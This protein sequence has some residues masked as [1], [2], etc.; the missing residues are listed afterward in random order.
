MPIP[1]HPGYT[2]LKRSVR[3]VSGRGGVDPMRKYRLSGLILAVLVLAVQ[4]HA[5]AAD[6]L[7][8]VVGMAAYEH[9]APLKNTV[10][11][12]RAIADT[13][14]RIGFN[15]VTLTDAT[16]DELLSTL[17]EFSFRAET[18]D[19]ALIYFAGHGVEVQGENFLIPV[20][21][22]VRSNRDVAARSVSLKDLLGAV[23]RA[24]K[25]RIVILDSCRDN[26]FGDV[27]APA[28]DPAKGAGVGRGGG[29]LA[30]PAPDRGTLVAFAARDGEIALDGDGDN[31]PFALALADTLARPGLEISLMFRQVRDA[32][33]AATGNRQEPHT[34]GSLPGA[35][36]YLA[37]APELRG[38]IDVAD[39]RVAW[40]RIRPDQ[41]S[42]LTR[43]AS[44]G[45]TR[46]M[47]G[48]AYMRLDPEGRD[49]APSDAAKWLEEAAGAG[50]AEAQFELAKLYET[51]LGVDADPARALAL[52]QEAAAQG[53]ADA[54]ND[55]GFLQYHGGLGLPRNVDKAL[56]HFERAADLR[57]PQA[58]FNFAALIDD[59]LVPGKGSDEAARY[60][61]G[62]LRAGSAEVFALLTERPTMFKDAT[63][64][65]LQAELR[66]HE[67]YK[68]AIDGD[69]GPG[70]QRSI[71]TA[72]GLGGTEAGP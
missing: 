61:Y 18:A 34:Y 23:D 28:S 64:R 50:S 4:S 31:S 2:F 24:R 25:M 1:R 20:D 52:H 7:G 43:L 53:F 38:E 37:G 11:D 71:R 67:F 69:F 65:A 54:I 57:H 49:Y 19:L 6:R 70:T 40:S 15:V 48:V 12:A 29:G 68:G 5:R 72:Y 58:M 66:R 51:G 13:L 26:P 59:G 35:P 39:R 33:L 42:Q 9:I 47:L 14:E 45:D 55:L 32:V 17:A 21:A 22:A 27:I 63:R 62:A 30:A 3:T 46:S 41:A 36:F 44:E 10:N 16:Q 8:L 56:E 60:L